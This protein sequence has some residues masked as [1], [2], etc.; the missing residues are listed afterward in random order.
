MKK[1]KIQKIELHKFITRDLEKKLIIDLK[2]FRIASEADLQSCAYLHLRR[3][4]NKDKKWSI[5]NKAFIMNLS[6]YPDFVIKRRGRVRVGIELKEKRILTPKE[7]KRDLKKLQKMW[8]NGKLF[9]K[10]YLIFLVR[11]K[12]PEKELRRLAKKKWR[13]DSQKWH[14]FPII[15]NARDYIKGKKWDIFREWWRNNSRSK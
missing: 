1:H 14:L 6:V 11:D 2:N 3:Y 10:G 4:L 13:T 12:K 7:V 9:N 8:K 15:I 5:L